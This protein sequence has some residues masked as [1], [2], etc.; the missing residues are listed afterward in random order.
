M[1]Y[2]Q[3]RLLD[4]TQQMNTADLKLYRET[5]TA[6]K[7]QKFISSLLN[8][9]LSLFFLFPTLFALIFNKFGLGLPS[10]GS[11][12]LFLDA[13]LEPTYITIIT[14]RLISISFF[15]E[16][17]HNLPLKELHLFGYSVRD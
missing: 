17:S 1:V 3:N 12:F 16:Y 14:F 8:K 5:H 6:S 9:K 13:S 10:T 11:S 2:A 7:L 4:Q 15:D